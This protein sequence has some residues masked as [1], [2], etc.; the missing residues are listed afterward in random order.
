MNWELGWRVVKKVL[1]S[2][3]K[4]RDEIEKNRVHPEDQVFDLRIAIG[5]KPDPIAIQQ[6]VRL[7]DKVQRR[8]H[9]KA[10]L[11]RICCKATWMQLGDAPS[12]YFFKLLRAKKICETIKILKTPNGRS[13]EDED[14]ILQGVLDHYSVMYVR[15]YRVKLLETKFSC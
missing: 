12:Q 3:S 6:L 1:K 14:K 5:P 2:I 8:D 10:N 11:W 9:T 13:I 7:E 15:D 4:E